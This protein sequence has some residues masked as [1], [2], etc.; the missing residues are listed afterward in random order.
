VSKH[1]VPTETAF[2]ADV[3]TKEEA[4]GAKQRPFR[5]TIILHFAV[6][7]SKEQAFSKPLASKIQHGPRLE[8][9]RSSPVRMP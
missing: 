3:K 2:I 9:N 1:S 8:Q 5:L 4:Q 6:F 7:I